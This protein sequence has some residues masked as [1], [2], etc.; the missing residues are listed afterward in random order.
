MSGVSLSSVTTSADDISTVGWAM[1][2]E[3]DLDTSL[4][5]TSQMQSIMSVACERTIPT[6][7]VNDGL[8]LGS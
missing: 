5:A 1:L 3:G 6:N 7:S 2:G 8:L 4:L